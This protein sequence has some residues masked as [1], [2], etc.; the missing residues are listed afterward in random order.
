MAKNREETPVM[1]RVTGTGEIGYF[2]REKDGGRFIVDGKA[3]RLKFGDDI[4]KM[5]AE[6]V[7]AFL[8]IGRD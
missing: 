6:D 8:S 2:E 1:Y 5:R 3:R 4:V 7:R